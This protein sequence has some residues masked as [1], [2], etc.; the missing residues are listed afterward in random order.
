MQKLQKHGHQ[1]N[2]ETEVP[3]TS[4]ELLSGDQCVVDCTI[5]QVLEGDMMKD[6]RIES[7]S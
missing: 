6:E 2:C 4:D 5:L 7:L 1:K 3:S